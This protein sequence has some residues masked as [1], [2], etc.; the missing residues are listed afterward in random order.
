[1][2]A[3]VRKGRARRRPVRGQQRALYALCTFLLAAGMYD[4]ASDGLW[5][6]ASLGYLS[7]SLTGLR[8]WLSIGYLACAAGMLPFLAA[9]AR[10]T[11][12]RHRTMLLLCVSC[13][14]ATLLWV[15]EMFVDRNANLEPISAQYIRYAFCAALFAVI[16]ASSFNTCKLRASGAHKH[17]AGKRGANRVPVK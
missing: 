7:A 2:S 6:P 12:V 13:L 16:V 3:V 11:A 10:P 14:A 15:G 8:E 4:T 5:Y 1:M 9:Q 17:R